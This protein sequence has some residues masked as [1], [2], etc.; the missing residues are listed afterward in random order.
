MGEAD[1][2]WL[3][4]EVAVVVVFAEDP[5]GVGTLGVLWEGVRAILA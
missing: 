2:A 5:G 4:A 1:L 3:T